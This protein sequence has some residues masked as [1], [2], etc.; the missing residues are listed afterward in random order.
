[1]SQNSNVK[2]PDINSLKFSQ[3]NQMLEQYR[4]NIYQLELRTDLLIKLLEEKNILI[5]EEFKRRWP[6]FLE[7]D[8]GHVGPDGIMKGSLKVSFFGE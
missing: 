2:E 7:N 1:M 6:A 8:I 5:P 4:M 3:I